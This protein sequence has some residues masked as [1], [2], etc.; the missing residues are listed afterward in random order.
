MSIISLT[1]EAAADILLRITGGSLKL[2]GIV[3]RD[4]EGKIRYI[5]RGFESLPKD[6]SQLSV[7]PALRPLRAAMTL[8]H[9]VQVV[10]IAQNAAVAASLHRIEGRLKNIEQHLND[11]LSRLTNVQI[12]ATLILAAITN[13]PTNRLKGAK[14]AARIALKNRDCTALTGAAQAA[15]HAARDILDQARNLVRVE[16]DGLPAALRMPQE[17][18]D[19]VASAADAFEVASAILVALERSDLASELLNEVVATLRGMRKRMAA[20]FD[21]PERMLRRSKVDATLDNRQV[22]AGRELRDAL[23]RCLGRQVLIE[24]GAIGPDPLRAEF[25][26][27]PRQEDLA[28]QSVSERPAADNKRGG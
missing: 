12:K 26:M 22:A 3:L 7:L 5:L 14:T 20:C 24:L 10:S 4:T 9:I 1:A 21:D 23:H 28:F 19:L 17:L 15:E 8:Q 6:A 13:S 16:D 27:A 2:D 18:A 11:I 25:E